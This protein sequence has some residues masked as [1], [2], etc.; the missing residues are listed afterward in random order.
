M[1]KVFANVNLIVSFEEGIIPQEKLNYIN[2]LIG[3]ILNNRLEFM[4]V[5]VEPTPLVTVEV[6]DIDIQIVDVVG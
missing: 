1:F 3:G 2:E 6:H 4:G 5:Q